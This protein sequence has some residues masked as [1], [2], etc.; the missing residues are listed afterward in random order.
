MLYIVATPIGNMGDITYRAVQTLAEADIIAAEDTRNTVKLLNRYEIHTPLVSFHEHSRADKYEKLYALLAEGKN[1]ALVSDAGTPLISDPGYE[2]VRGARERGYG[3]ETLPG[4]CALITGLVLS[5]IS[6][7]KFVFYGFLPKDKTR[8]RVIADMCEQKHTVVMYESPHGILKTLAEL[9]EV[10]PDRNISLCRE[11]T[12]LH[13]EV[14][15]LT[16]KGALEHFKGTPPRGE[17]VMVMQGAGDVKHEVSDEEIISEIN[18]RTAR[19]D[20]NKTACADVATSLGVNKNRVYK[21]SLG[22]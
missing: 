12:K 15:N 9:A 17:F 6:C 7:E 18:E 22:K 20:S 19:G 4:A 10:I 1:V 21:L 5:G 8:K 11:I 14:L 3:V 13:E 16:V 2:L